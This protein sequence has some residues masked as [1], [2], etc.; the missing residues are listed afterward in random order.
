MLGLDNCVTAR[1]EQLAPEHVV[2]LKGVVAG[3]TNLVIGLSS[4]ARVRAP[5][6]PS[7]LLRR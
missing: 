2:A 6:W 4:P 7:S 3:G 5:A 1:I